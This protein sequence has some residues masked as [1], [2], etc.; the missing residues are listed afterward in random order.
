M[1]RPDHAA[2]ADAFMAERPDAWAMFEGIALEL[3]ESGVRR[4]SADHIFH[5]MR[6]R[7]NRY[8]LLLGAKPLQLNNV[9]TARFAR[10]W[11]EEHPEYPSFFELRGEDDAPRATSQMELGI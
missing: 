8:A 11:L 7:I 1:P 9:W 3:A 5:V 6:Q 10:R 4:S 2:A